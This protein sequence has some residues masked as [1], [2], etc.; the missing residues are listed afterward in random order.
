M[1]E[2]SLQIDLPEVDRKSLD[3]AIQEWILKSA[4]NSVTAY[5]QKAA[6]TVPVQTG[7]ARGVFLN[8][9]RALKISFTTGLRPQ[10]HRIWRGTPYYGETRHPRLGTKFS[11][12]NLPTKRNPTQFRFNVSLAYMV[13]NATT[14]THIRST[15]WRTFDKGEKALDKSLKAEFKNFPNILKFIKVRSL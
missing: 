12:Y 7:M 15:P 6:S 11:S 13:L 10:R 9:S 2:F 3:Q 8:I 5:V 14:K 1:F 4:R